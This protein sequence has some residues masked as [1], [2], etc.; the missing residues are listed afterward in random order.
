MSIKQ[1]YRSLVVISLIVVF[2]SFTTA[3]IA[4]LNL[5]MHANI[6]RTYAFVR[7]FMVRPSHFFAVENST[8]KGVDDVHD[9]LP[10]Q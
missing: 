3:L 4:F 10:R 9:T 7:H 6:D 8:Y 1:I 2:G 5:V